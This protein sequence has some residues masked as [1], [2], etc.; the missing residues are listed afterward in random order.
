MVE[1]IVMALLCHACGRDLDILGAVGRRDECTFCGADLHAC[2]G[3][4][5]YD[6]TTRKKCREP[7]AEPPVSKTDGNACE[8]FIYA[9]TRGPQEEADES[10]AAR[11]RLEALFSGK[12]AAPPAEDDPQADARRRLD[13]L[14]KKK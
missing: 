4:V 10:V 14:F 9:R 12:P 5:A 7:A 1:N 8:F 13:D 3:C 11:A 6:P 2:V